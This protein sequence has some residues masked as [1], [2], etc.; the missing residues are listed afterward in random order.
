M[1]GERINAHF[2]EVLNTEQGERQAE[3]LR[4]IELVTR[5][6][7]KRIPVLAA[8]QGVTSEPGLHV[9]DETTRKKGDIV[10]ANFTVEPT[11]LRGAAD[12]AHA[13][14]A[15]E[16]QVTY[17]DGGAG[18][19]VIAAKSYGSK[20]SFEDRLTRV[21]REVTISKYMASM[22]ELA[23]EPIAVAVAPPTVADNAVVLFTRL[24][25]GLYTLD[26]TP[27]GRGLT[28]H[29]VA[30][31]GTAALAVGHCNALGIEH[32]DAKIKNVGSLS[33]GKVGMVDFETSR[34]INASNPAEAQ[35]AAYADFGLFTKSLEDKGFFQ[36]RGDTYNQG[37]QVVDAVRTMC[38]GY[39]SAWQ[40]SPPEV[41]LAVMEVVQDIGQQYASKHAPVPVSI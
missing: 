3:A 28:R 17:A 40:D 7:G 29:N 31:A 32:N 13:V 30:I 9:I 21:Q 24:D 8:E 36:G 19:T 6:M 12:S 1:A 20:R 37:K 4:T 16:M 34:Q 39:L 15:G 27:W 33:S 35:S 18:A 2:A 23:L 26:S 22:G 14:L 41:Q 38:D 11:M 10:H 5:E 25:S